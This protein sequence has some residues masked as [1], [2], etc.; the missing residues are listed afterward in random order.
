MEKRHGLKAVAVKRSDV[1]IVPIDE[2][3][4]EPGFN[5]RLNYEGIQEFA[6]FIRE[7]GVLALPPLFVYT[8]QGR[9]YISDGHRRI[10]AVRL[11]S[12]EG[13]EIK[14][15]PC[16]NDPLNEEE[17][18]LA[19]ITRNSGAPLTKLEQGMVFLRML[20]FGWQQN[21]IAKKVAKSPAYVN[22]CIALANAP[23]KVQDLLTTRVVNDSTVLTMLGNVEDPEQIYDIIIESVNEV[24]ANMAQEA[25]VL[26]T[27][28]PATD[29][30]VPIPVVADPPV[31]VVQRNI[32][33]VVR[34]KIGKETVASRM[35]ILDSWIQENELLYKNNQRYNV[36]RDV[37]AFLKGEKT[38]D[39]IV[40]PVNA[41]DN[42]MDNAM[43]KQGE[44]PTEEIAAE[45]G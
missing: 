8:K 12:E 10:R 23:Q 4:E 38:W 11:V 9:I 42:A 16:Q 31:E 6:D 39:E 33:R 15:I 21:Q 40:P 3:H 36:V 7:N 29:A 22:Q 37:Y 43:D 30:D 45:Q 26:S 27:G 19:M 2:L 41:T 13:V 14:G 18:T 25:P 34:N 35:K 32:A 24:K 17:R 44:T 1:F 5:A 20:R 28:D